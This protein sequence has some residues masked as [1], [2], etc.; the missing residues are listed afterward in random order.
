ML[1][2]QALGYA[3]IHLL[4][5]ILSIIL[6]VPVR[7]VGLDACS[8][9][10]VPVGGVVCANVDVYCCGNRGGRGCRDGRNFYCASGRITKDGCLGVVGDDFLGRILSI[11]SVSYVGVVG[12]E[13][14]IFGINRI[15]FL[16]FVLKPI[17]NDGIGGPFLNGGIGGPVGS[18][19]TLWDGIGG[20]SSPVGSDI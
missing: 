17:L 12:D 9:G 5:I 7:L 14:L 19:L 15:D 2:P 8:W 20:V 3:S 16:P 1:V 18:D 11:D 6:P 13:F 10:N 4:D